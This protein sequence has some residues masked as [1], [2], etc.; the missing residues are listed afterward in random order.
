MQKQIYDTVIIGAGASGLMAAVTAARKGLRVLVLEHMEQAAKKI[1]ATGNGKCNYTNADQSLENYY[2]EEPDFIRTVLAQF[3]C[4]DTIRFFEELGIRPVQKNGTCMYPESGQASSVKNV[5]LAEAQRLDIPILFS[6]GIRAVHK[7]DSKEQLRIEQ[8]CKEQFRKEQL[9][10]ERFWKGLFRIETKDQV[11]IGR[12]C[13]LAT[14]GKAMKKTGSDG[15]GYIYARQ[16]GHSIAAPLPALTALLTNETDIRLPAGIRVFCAA[17]LYVDHEPKA[18]ECGELQIT[19]YGISGIVI[20]QSARIVSRALEQKRHVTVCLDFQ[21]DLQM[22]L[23]TAYLGSRFLSIYHRHQKLADALTGRLPDKL[24]GVVLKRAGLDAGEVCENL[25]EKQ[26]R[27][28]AGQMKNYEVTVTGTKGFDHAQVTTGGVP[29][30]EIFAQRMESKIVPGLYFAGEIVD[31]DGKCGGY[32]L[33]WAWSS[34]Y[35]AAD[36]AAKRLHG[37]RQIQTAAKNGRKEHPL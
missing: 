26:I 19:D 20:F 16:L 10:K 14:G 4:Q 25:T 37:Q 34:G 21:P 22:E 18:C 31:V 28:L 2:C 30:Q 17:A 7:T 8:L 15:S 13:I 35:V 29:V 3:S 24:T 33:Q 23:L 11:Y 27:R 36:S 32:N 9:H 5:L 1:L 12:T 6:V